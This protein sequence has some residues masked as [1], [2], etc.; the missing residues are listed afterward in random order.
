MSL[1]NYKGNRFGSSTL[2]TNGN[3]V[4]FSN[5]D[6]SVI[7]NSEIQ[8]TYK[9]TAL[10]SSVNATKTGDYPVFLPGDNAISFSGGITSLEITPNWWWL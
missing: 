4:S 7:L 2:T 8:E 5:I 3:L 6:E 10:R 1:P 9:D